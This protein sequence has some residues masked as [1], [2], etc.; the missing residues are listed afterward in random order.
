MTMGRGLRLCVF[1]LEGIY[2]DGILKGEG[3]Y[4]SLR[5]NIDAKF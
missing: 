5:G 1:F 2:R 4:G 3:R